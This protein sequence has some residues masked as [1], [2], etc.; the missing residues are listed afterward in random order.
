VDLAAAIPLAFAVGFF[1]VVAVGLVAV[2]LV[3]CF[4]RGA[5]PA[6]IER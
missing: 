4:G 6:A 3:R 2:G 5:A 1:V